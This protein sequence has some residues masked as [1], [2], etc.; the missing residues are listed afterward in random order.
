MRP[1]V[2]KAQKLP[3][4][5]PRIAQPR[6]RAGLVLLNAVLKIAA[7]RLAHRLG[8]VANALFSPPAGAI[9]LPTYSVTPDATSSAPVGPELGQPNSSNV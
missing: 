3:P 7:S 9:D 5:A 1:Y 2:D 4:G 6:T 8:G